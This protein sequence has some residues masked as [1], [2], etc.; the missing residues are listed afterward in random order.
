MGG[1]DEE[2]STA[3]GNAKDA[4]DNWELEDHVREILEDLVIEC[5]Y[6]AQFEPYGYGTTFT[7]GEANELAGNGKIKTR[8]EMI[9]DQNLK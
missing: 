5:N 7:V 9:N 8:E 6:L 3:Q 4:L 2:M 1:G